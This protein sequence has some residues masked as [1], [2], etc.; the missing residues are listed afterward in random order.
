MIGRNGTVEVAKGK[1]RWA[2]F[3]VSGGL[4]GG[5]PMRLEPHGDA[6]GLCV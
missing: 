3:G 5:A 2:L 1:P 4:G 6:V